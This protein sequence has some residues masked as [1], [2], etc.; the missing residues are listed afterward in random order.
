MKVGREGWE[1]GGCGLQE[2][3]ASWWGSHGSTA[4][5]SGGHERVCSGLA[6]EGTSRFKSHLS[7]LGSVFMSDAEE[8]V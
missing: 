3:Y 4:C 7:F 2:G 6:E 5:M 1:W 8:E